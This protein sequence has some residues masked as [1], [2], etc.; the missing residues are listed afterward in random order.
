M[1]WLRRQLRLT[2]DWLNEKLRR[3]RVFKRELDLE[4]ALDKAQRELATLQQGAIICA[5]PCGGLFWGPSGKL[6]K[7]ETPDGD[8]WVCVRCFNASVNKGALRKK[9]KGKKPRHRQK[10]GRAGRA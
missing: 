10:M 7:V 2:A 3:V 1:T 5:G 4:L 6:K 9:T 8:V